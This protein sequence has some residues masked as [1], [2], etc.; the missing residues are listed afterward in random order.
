MRRARRWLGGVATAALCAAVLTPTAAMAAGTDDALLADL[1]FESGTTAFEGGGA[2]AAVQGTATLVD[3]PTGKAAKLGSGFWL[4]VTKADGTPLLAGR[5]DVTIS[6]DSKPDASGNT[7]WSVFAARSTATQTYQQEHYLGFLDKTTGI[8]V[9]RYDNAGTR[10]SSGNLVT[11]TANTAWKHVDLV[12]SGTTARLFVDRKLVAT[13]TTGKALS[14]I[15]GATGG[16]LQ[17]G[18]ANWGSGEYF[19]G[20][21]D[22]VRVYSRALTPTELGVPSA[23]SDPAAA[24]AIPAR[25]TGDLPS[26]VLGR[27]VTWSASGDGASLVASDGAVTRPADGAVAVTLTATIDGVAAPVTGSAQILDAGGDIASYVKHVTTVNGVKDDPL[28]YDEDRRADSLF[29]A[30]RPAGAATWEPLNR[31]QAILSVLWDGTQAAKPNAQVGSPTLLR[32]ADGTLGAVASQN[33]ATDSVYVWDA[34]D[35]ATFRNQRTVKVSSDGSIVADPRIVFDAASQKYQ[36]T[37]T[38]PLTG[39]GRVARLDG[40]TG[41]SVPTAATKADA[42]ALGVAGAATGLPGFAAEARSFALS[43]A[44]FAAFS[45]RYVDLRNTGVGAFADVEVEHGATVDAG[46]L[47]ATATLEYNDGSTK[48]LPVAWSETDLADVDTDTPGTYDVSGTVQQT[49]EELVNDARADPDLFFNEDDGYWY[50]TGSHYSIPSDAPNSALID[51]N[52][53]RKIGLKRATTIAGLADAPEQI[54]IDPDAGTPGRQAQ[55]PNTFYGWGGYI[56]AQEFHKI[57]GQWWIVAGM[58]RGYAPTG[59]WCDN[60]VLIPYIGSDASLRAGGLVDQA[61]WG[62][63][64]I[65]EGAAFD[66][67]YLEREEHGTTQGYWV[68][69]SGAKLFVGKAKAGPKGT[70]PLIDGTLS[71]IYALSQPWEYGKSAPTPSDVNEGGDQGIVEAPF[72]VTYGDFV[73]LTYSGGTVDKYYD[74]GLLRAAK[75]ADLRNPASWTQVPFPVLTTNDTASGRIGGVGQGG[76]GHNSFAIDEAG[77]LVLAYH[78][79]PYPEP[80]TNSAAGGLFDPDR[81][82]WFK[83]VNVRANGDLDLSL[84]SAQEVAPA[85]RTVTVRVVVGDPPPV[86]LRVSATTR[87]VAGKVVLVATLANDGAAA[88]SAHVTTGSGE[89]AVELPAGKAVAISFTTRQKAL[90]A[91]TITVVTSA[92]DAPIQAAYAAAECR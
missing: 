79:R 30:A 2:R 90:E 66:V 44:E 48:Q 1:A 7:G 27:A 92:S 45:A 84:S 77:N 76:P 22:N 72:M 71:Q 29:V 74:L 54:V 39:E 18:K 6:Y 52:A 49:A 59:G 42:V 14:T 46:D 28:A 26:S 80:H 47:P 24:L 63:P 15:L 23:A 17:V 34:A 25:I 89:K 21:V 73:Y 78:A 33:N 68:M 9:E 81:N 31:S 35:G 37:W 53:Y 64:T 65:L 41:A 4:N 40:L 62:E 8:T 69:P 10:D 70:V 82:T 3:G 36:A 43:K 60:T 91:G 57:N 56:W 86:A 32:F 12:L 20:L 50:L 75:D 16:V 58:N 87:C 11:T 38:D 13:N 83:A 61:N 55:Y 5:D 88:E 67:S 51:A 85:N 19:G